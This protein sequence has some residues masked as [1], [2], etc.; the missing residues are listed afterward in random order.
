MLTSMTLTKIIAAVDSFENPKVIIKFPEKIHKQFY[1][2]ESRTDLKHEAVFK[3]IGQIACIQVV[4]GRVRTSHRDH[5]LCGALP[6]DGGAPRQ[7]C[8][9]GGPQTSST[10]IA[11]DPPNLNLHLIRCPEYVSA[12]WGLRNIV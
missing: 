12:G 5:C 4:T 10:S 11:W 2:L 9:L 8:A 1:H 6:S 7:P 3:Q